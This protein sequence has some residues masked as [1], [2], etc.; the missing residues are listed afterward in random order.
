MH[1]KKNIQLS[2]SLLEVDKIAGQ[3]IGILGVWWE[4]GKGRRGE[5]C[6]KGRL[7]WNLGQWDDWDK[8]R[9]VRGTGKHTS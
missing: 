6:E 9:F 7:G 5:K 3:K 1:A 8:G 4:E 2:S